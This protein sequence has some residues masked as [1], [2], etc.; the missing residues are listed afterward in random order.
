M[1]QYGTS[2]SI[3]QSQVTFAIRPSA[4]NS[5]RSSSLNADAG[6]EKEVGRVE[7][8]TAV[9]D[10]ERPELEPTARSKVNS[11]GNV[12]RSGDGKHDRE[13]LCGPTATAQRKA[14]DRIEEGG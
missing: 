2:A 6:A 11:P 8:H 12:E 3:I 10:R 14:I 5:P 7:Q 13:E 9:L 1:A 4:A